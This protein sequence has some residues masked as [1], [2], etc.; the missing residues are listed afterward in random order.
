MPVSQLSW[1]TRMV[2]SNK[3]GKDTFIFIV[4]ETAKYKI[5]GKKYVSGDGA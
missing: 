2:L 4:R 5:D 3:S 1:I